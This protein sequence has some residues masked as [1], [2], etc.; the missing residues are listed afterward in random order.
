MRYTLVY[1]DI[2]INSFWFN[3]NEVDYTPKEHQKFQK[4]PITMVVYEKFILIPWK[5]LVPF[6]YNL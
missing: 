1:R 2:E 4:F 3:F 5:L 6:L